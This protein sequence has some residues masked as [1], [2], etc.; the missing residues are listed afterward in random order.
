MIVKPF[1][2]GRTYNG[3]IVTFGYLL[4][5]RVS[6]GTS[7]VLK[8]DSEVTLALIKE[9]SKKQKW[10]WSSGVLSF[11]ETLDDDTKRSIMY[12]FE[13]VFF[14]GLLDD[15]YDIT[16]INHE[17]K[18]RTELHYMSPRL[19]LATGKALNMYFV[20]R[21]FRKKEIFQEYMNLKYGLTSIIDNPQLA[22]YKPDRIWEKELDLDQGGS[23]RSVKKQIDKQLKEMVS[24]GALQSR[25][26]VIDVLRNTGLE[27]DDKIKPNVIIL[28]DKDGKSHILKGGFYSEDFKSGVSNLREKLS[29]KNIPTIKIDGEYKKSR[30]IKE[31]ERALW[32]IVKK[33]AYGNGKKYSIGIEEKTSRIIESS[34]NLE[35][36]SMEM[37]ISE[38]I[39]DSVGQTA[40]DKK[41]I[42]KEQDER[43][44]SEIN[45]ILRE[46][47]EAESRRKRRIFESTRVATALHDS[48]RKSVTDAYK[49]ITEAIE[50]GAERRALEEDIKHTFLIIDGNIGEIQRGLIRR[51]NTV[52]QGL[53]QRNSRIIEAI[54]LI[55][56]KP[57]ENVVVQARLRNT[58]ARVSNNKKEVERG[59]SQTI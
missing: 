13:K 48:I 45:R 16:W 47:R 23:W 33:Q 10:S 6:V 19:E 32:E 9:A 50:I 46:S 30:D 7:R 14:C 37:S 44:R 18:G 41:N 56:N 31:L 25:N 38:G 4:N 11:S 15:Q 1:K 35:L 27:L 59:K 58:E 5:D 52:E 54:E 3:A 36:K 49:A 28:L 43:D 55:R 22:S 40:E 2:G 8:G 20:K 29:E 39:D 53:N 26:D 21:D 17:D 34:I 42:K 57:G 12:V 24:R 51:N